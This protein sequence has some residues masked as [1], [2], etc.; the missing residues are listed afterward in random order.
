MA[1]LDSLSEAKAPA[2]PLSMFQIIALVLSGSLVGG[3]GTAFWGAT[4]M[5]P[6]R[7]T[8]ADGENLQNQIN[9]IL[10]SRGQR[11]RDE[12]AKMATLVESIKHLKADIAHLEEDMA[13]QESI[14][15]MYD[16][17]FHA[18]DARVTTIESHKEKETEYLSEIRSDLKTIV[19]K[20]TELTS[21]MKILNYR[22]DAHMGNGHLKN[23]N[24]DGT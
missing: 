13:R 5:V 12:D 1:I 15:V 17:E 23:A 6:D 14:A 18:L 9:G 4:Q 2:T 8:G 3:G 19:P 10:I 21:E 24:G 22:V 16:T 20:I 11:Q 7:F